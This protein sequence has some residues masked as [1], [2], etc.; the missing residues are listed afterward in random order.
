MKFATINLLNLSASSALVHII[1]F[2]SCEH[3]VVAN[4]RV[5]PEERNFVSPLEESAIVIS[6]FEEEAECSLALSFHVLAYGAVWISRYRTLLG[7]CESSF[8]FID[9]TNRT[10]MHGDQEL[11]DVAYWRGVRSIS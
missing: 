9:V 8:I 5:G 2:V 11:G 6:V 3:D 10:A 7:Q 1:E 4:R